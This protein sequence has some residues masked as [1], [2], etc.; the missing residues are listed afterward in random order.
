MMNGKPIKRQF[1]VLFK[2]AQDNLAHHEMGSFSF[3]PYLLG[4][5]VQ[6]LALDAE[7]AVNHAK[8]SL[9]RQTNPYTDR[10]YWVS[11]GVVES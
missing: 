10:P 2:P 6:V 7:D 9:A 3:Q 11:V 4:F 5:E 8:L 1:T